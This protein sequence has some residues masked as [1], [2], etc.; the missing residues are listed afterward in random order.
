MLFHQITRC[1]MCGGSHLE[2]VLDLGMQALTG[3]FPDP[4]EQ[5][6]EAP[7]ELVRCAGE[8]TCGL[9]QLHH[10]F[11]LPA[12]YG[13]RYGYRSGLNA[14]MVR[15]LFAKVARIRS[16][17]PVK[18]GD[19]IL[20]IGSNDGTTLSAWTETGITRIGIDPTSNRFREYY[21]EGCTIVPDFFSRDRFR[22]VAGDR[23]AGVITSFAMFYD[24][25]EPLLFMQHIA[26]CLAPD[27]VWVF[28]QSYLPAMLETN[29]Y[30][31]ICHEHLEFY[32]LAQI[33]WG[34]ERAGLKIIDVEFND[35][36]G[37]SFS[38]T[39]ALKD[40]PLAPNQTLIDSILQNE[41]AIGLMTD[42]P[43]TEFVT[44]INEGREQLLNYLVSARA[45]GK[46]VLG[47]GASTKGN[48]LLQYCGITPELVEA[49]GEVNPDKFGKV[50]P[51]S[52][53]PIVPQDEVLRAGA[54]ALL[55]LPWHFRAFFTAVPA[56]KGQQL[57][58]P[59]PNLELIHV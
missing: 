2:S 13:D 38:V 9:V 37:G 54:E 29:S 47:L 43:Y 42:T 41:I 52:R 11:S 53:I 34:L 30:D 44:R 28:E 45:A 5:V 23:K 56:L 8:G 1:R 6:P 18:S 22:E 51:G 17:R 3:W 16:L 46:K 7:L 4:D 58:F 26:D 27:G 15:H 24:L 55:V 25:E 19:V 36:N 57:L 59:L 35:I 50:T 14:S 10:T 31:T 12:M 40:S 49:I 48:V 21:P 32:A 39:A 33:Q 20:D